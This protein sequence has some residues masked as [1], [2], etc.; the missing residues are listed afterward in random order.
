MGEIVPFPPELEV[1]E[2]VF[3]LESKLAPGFEPL[4]DDGVTGAEEALKTPDAGL[5][6]FPEAVP[7]SDETSTFFNVVPPLLLTAIFW[8][9]I[10]EAADSLTPLEAGV[11]LALPWRVECGEDWVPVG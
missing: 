8:S 4:E 7:N 6:V 3:N 1:D 11:L 9:W 5:A 10:R 2:P